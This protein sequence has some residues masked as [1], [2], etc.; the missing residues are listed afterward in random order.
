MSRPQRPLPLLLSQK[1]DSF[2]LFF[3]QNTR[4]LLSKL[5]NLYTDG[6]S[7]SSHVFV[8]TE[9]WLKPDILSSEVFPS[10]YTTYVLDRP[11]RR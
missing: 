3:Y 6:F 7:A 8:F 10:K 11:T 4:G 1:L 5:T 9:T 2:L